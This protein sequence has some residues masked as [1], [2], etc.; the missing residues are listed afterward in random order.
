MPKDSKLVM[1]EGDEEVARG[2]YR[3]LTYHIEQITDTRSFTIK[4]I[5]KNGDTV[6]DRSGKEVIGYCTVNVNKCFI[7]VIINFIK[8]LIGKTETVKVSVYD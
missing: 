2:N 3:V 7:T 6:K 1:Y 8:S 4:A 5:D